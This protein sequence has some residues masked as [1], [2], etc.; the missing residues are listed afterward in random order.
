MNITIKTILRK[1]RLERKASTMK[2]S[3]AHIKDLK[4]LAKKN[5]ATQGQ[6]IE[7]ALDLFNSL[8]K[9]KIKITKWE[10]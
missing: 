10:K 3:T 8:S 5:K 2:L 1:D 9:N 4:R 6:I 7:S